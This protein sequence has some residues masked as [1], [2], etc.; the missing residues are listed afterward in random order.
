VVAV[1]VLLLIG[2]M[3]IRETL[4]AWS[5]QGYQALERLAGGM[6]QALGGSVFGTTVSDLIGC[7]LLVTA[8]VVLWR[9]R[10]ASG[11]GP[12]YADPDAQLGLPVPALPLIVLR[13]ARPEPVTTNPRRQF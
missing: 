11:D 5:R 10:L 12:T 1:S 13:D 9:A 7:A 4:L 6:L 2:Q 3:Q 8:L